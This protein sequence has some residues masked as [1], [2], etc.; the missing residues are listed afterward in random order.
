ML[1]Y[2][3]VKYDLALFFYIRCGKDY[4]TSLSAQ[5][6]VHLT[7]A[8]NECCHCTFSPAAPPE[9][10]YVSHMALDQLSRPPPSLSDPLAV[11]K[12]IHFRKGK[13]CL[14]KTT[15]STI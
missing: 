7:A 5:Y 8:P 3:I 9:H 6:P 11:V 12:I 14:F 1:Q 10:G 4:V 13:K 15:D 2:E